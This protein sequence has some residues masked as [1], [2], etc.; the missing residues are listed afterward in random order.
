[1]MMMMM[2]RLVNDFPGLSWCCTLSSLLRR[3]W[4]GDRKGIRPV[5]NPRYLLPVICLEQVAEEKERKGKK[6]IY[7][8]PLL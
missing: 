3:S 8:A 4:F 6:C 5:E 7:I 1:M 2:M